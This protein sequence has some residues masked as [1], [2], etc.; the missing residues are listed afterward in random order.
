MLGEKDVDLRE[1]KLSVMPAGRLMMNGG[2]SVY[3][4][5]KELKGKRSR[6]LFSADGRNGTV[7]QKILNEGDWRWRVT[8]H[9]GVAYGAAYR[10]GRLG[11][12]A[13]GPEW[14]LTLDRSRDALQWDL[15]KTLEVTG[16]PNETTRRFQANG[17]R[18]ALVRREGRFY[19]FRRHGKGARY[20]VE[21]AGEPSPVFWGAECDPVA[22]RHVAGGF[23]RLYEFA[24]WRQDGCGDAARG[25]A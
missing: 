21:L 2:G 11:S 18:V 10:S 17:D 15:V 3:L 6:G 24:R 14:G 12:A 13:L 9:E 23:A 1:P 22:R 20:A 7:P 16:R 25:L 19:G 5:T 4:G 8:G